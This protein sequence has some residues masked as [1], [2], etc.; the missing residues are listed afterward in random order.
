MKDYTGYEFDPESNRLIAELDFLDGKTDIIQPQVDPKDPYK[1]P[2]IGF[3]DRKVTVQDR[4]MPYTMYVPDGFRPY[5]DGIFIFV[6]G[7]CTARTYLEEKGWNHIA[8]Q[9]R[10]T[11]IAMQCSKESWGRWELS[12]ALAYARAVFV[13]QSKRDICSLNEGGFY[14]LGF[15]DGAYM[16]TIFTMLYSSVFAAAAVCGPVK[17]EEE[18]IEKISSLPADGDKTLKKNQIPI[19][20]WMIGECDQLVPYFCH[21]ANTDKGICT[22]HYVSFRQKQIPYGHIINEQQVAEVRYSSNP[23]AAGWNYQK[24]AERMVDFVKQFKKQPGIKERCLRY[25]QTAEEMGLKYCEA[26]VNGVK[27]CWY[28]FEPTAYRKKSK[29]KYPVVFGMHG[30]CT[31]GETFACHA[32]WHRVAEARGFLVV[33]P[34]GYMQTYGACMAPTLVWKGYEFS[35]VESEADDIAFFTYMLQY[36]K[37]HYPV[38]EERIYATGHSNGSAMTQ[39]LIRKM[40]EHFAAFGPVGYTDGD[41]NPSMVVP[42]FEHETVCP[43]WLIK[44]E[45]DIGCGGSLKEGNANVT[46]LR[47]LCSLNGVTYENGKHYRNEPFDNMTFYNDQQVPVVRYSNVQ[48]MPHSITPEIA[49]MLWDQY[50]CRF[51]RRED[52]SIE[53]LG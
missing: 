13:V 27:R 3:F 23:A 7:G 43:T 51:I 25:T 11:L 41:L 53:Y 30:I 20:M 19:S 40:P 15:E 46:M 47:H 33:Y 24:T 42:P 14:A 17:I 44:G 34:F 18:L 12:D 21:S 1:T 5:S 4:E 9:K 35:E 36:M 32:Q 39:M 26:E 31:S 2:H 49:W 8:E 48:D 29:E 22:E 37:D 16:A 50:F 45:K 52:G 28:V 10:V 38:D 6:P